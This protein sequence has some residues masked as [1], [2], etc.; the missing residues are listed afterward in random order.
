M[1]TV[2]LWP[3]SLRLGHKGAV[4]DQSA[5]VQAEGGV[6]YF[7]VARQAGS[8][9]EGVVGSVLATE[10]CATAVWK[11]EMPA[12]IWGRGARP[13]G[14]RCATKKRASRDTVYLLVAIYESATGPC[15]HAALMGTSPQFQ[16]VLKLQLLRPE[17]AGR[18]AA[19]LEK[20]GGAMMLE[21]EGGAMEA[22][23]EVGSATARAAG[24][25]AVERAVAVRAA[26]SASARAAVMT[27]QRR[28]WWSR[29][30]PKKCLPNSGCR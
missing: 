11:V 14:V 29:L 9:Q 22:V 13:S 26:G 20:E 2:T 5:L 28:Q 3:R 16:E 8:R 15:W 30:K 25:V 7:D 24:R 6:L 4:D 19:V 21:K 1:P 18:V 12:A 23:R 27:P 10:V 17:G